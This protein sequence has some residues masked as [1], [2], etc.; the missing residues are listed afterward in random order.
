M[1][2]TNIQHDVR[3]KFDLSLNEYCVAEVVDFFARNPENKFHWCYA[4][5][6]TIGSILGLSKQ[7]ILNIIEKLIK[8]GIVEKHEQTKNLRT[9]SKWYNA[10]I[11]SEEKPG[12]ETLPN[13]GKES[14]PA[15]KKLD[16]DGKET[17]PQPGKETLPYIEHNTINNENELI[18]KAFYEKIIE[19]KEKNPAKYPTRLYDNFFTYWTETKNDIA[20]KKTKFQFRFQGQEYFDIGKRLATY[21]GFVKPDKKEEMWKL[22]KMVN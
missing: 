12:K 3:R 15:V 22:H 7:T 9:T 21:W 16:E 13:N 1:I 5:K 19:W 10:F 17:L 8:S 4:S 6:E 11:L 20:K 14:L 2:Y 18:K